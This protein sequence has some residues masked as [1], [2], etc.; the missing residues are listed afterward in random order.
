MATLGTAP[1]PTSARTRAP[2]SALP[3]AS[4]CCWWPHSAASLT[5]VPRD[6]GPTG[7]RRWLGMKS[8]RLS[9]TGRLQGAPCMLVSRSEGSGCALCSSV[10]P[11]G[12]KEEGREKP[13]W[14]PE[15]PRPFWLRPG[16]RE[17]GLVMARAGPSWVGA[18]GPRK[19]GHSRHPPRRLP[20]PAPRGTM[21]C[22]LG[23]RAGAPGGGWGGEE[24][25]EDRE[26]R[27]APGG[28]QASPQSSQG[29]G[30]RNWGGGS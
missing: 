29:E 24:E 27:P 25:E 2:G 28:L 4:T 23:P 16:G 21:G 9:P 20:V 5:R 18:Q 17:E 11:L 10:R 3:P 13:C 22:L 14:A 8:S 7:A 26:G 6:D 1:L 12:G 30:T 19:Q 15:P